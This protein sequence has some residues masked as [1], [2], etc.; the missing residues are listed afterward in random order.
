MAD[1]NRHWRQW[2]RAVTLASLAGLVGWVAFIAD[3]PVPLLDW[4]D[5]AIHE[6]GHLLAFPLP[7]LVMF[8]AGSFLQIAFPAAMATY[9]IWKRKD[10][11]A[12]GFCLA[13]AGTSAWD[14]S[15]YVADAPVQ[16]L[17]LIGGGEHDWAYILGHFNAIGRAKE[18]AGFIETLG[19]IAVLAGIFVALL[20]LAAT[21][22]RARPERT[23]PAGPAEAKVR[24]PREWPADPAGDP[25]AAEQIPHGFD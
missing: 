17:P 13:W 1:W 21:P 19:A 18:I 22:Q 5:L 15:V 3:R 6:T 7:R 12:G 20:S 24:E 2:A 9:F 8:M 23:R 25:W 16:A 11:P 14:V 10:L 4:F